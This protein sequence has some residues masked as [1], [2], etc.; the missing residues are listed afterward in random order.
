MRIE[1]AQQ[2]LAKLAA[3]FVAEKLKLDQ[4]KYTFRVGMEADP[5]RPPEE[6]ISAW[7]TLVEK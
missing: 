4:S 6:M 5:S 7:V 2:D 1:V 3:R